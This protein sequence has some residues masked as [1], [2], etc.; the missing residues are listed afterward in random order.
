MKPVL[1]RELPKDREKLLKRAAFYEWLTILSFVST[2]AILFTV[3]GGSQSARA[4]WIQTVLSLVP[5]IAWLVAARV[6][7][8]APNPMFP[9]GYHKSITLAFLCG[10]VTLLLLGAVL[11]YEGLESLLSGEHPTVGNVVL[12]GHLIWQ[13]WLMIGAL[14]LSMIP[15]FLLGR[16][17]LKLA[18]QLHDKA[19]FSDARMNAADWLSASAAIV[20]VFGIGLGW[21]WLD[22]LAASFISIDILYD[23]YKNVRMSVADLMDRAP[24]TVDHEALE[25]LPQH[26]VAMLQDLDWVEEAQVRLREDGHV[27]FGEAFVRANDTTHL[28]EK[29]ASAAEMARR[30]DWRLQELVVMPVAELL[31][32]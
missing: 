15:P 6:R 12:F 25:R 8:R 2:A 18:S 24:H 21:W 19:L 23:G 3:L 10:S 27:F 5:P 22:G 28:V 4:E 32:E 1:Q 29:L 13:G 16:V 14:L 7:Q 17:K 31:P 26:L 11:L 30:L 9:Y 20:G